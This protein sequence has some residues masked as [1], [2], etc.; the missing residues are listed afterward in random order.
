[1]AG[2][3]GRELSSGEILLNGIE[4][5]RYRP[6]LSVGEVRAHGR[7]STDQPTS[8]SVFL[9]D[10][11]EDISE[12]TGDD[13]NKHLASND[14]P[15]FQLPRTIVVKS[16]DPDL[17]DD[18][19]EKALNLMSDSPVKGRKYDAELLPA[20]AEESV[21]KV[22]L[23][24][25]NQPSHPTKIQLTIPS[26]ASEDSADYITDT[27]DYDNICTGELSPVSERDSL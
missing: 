1:M 16:K 3:R 21:E 13:Q 25:S 15:D 9:S 10:K 5:G 2:F 24:T 23:D 20:S 22:I 18:D 7:P 17:G 19:D 11:E 27:L 8:N 12:I 14:K 6:S 4:N 26:V